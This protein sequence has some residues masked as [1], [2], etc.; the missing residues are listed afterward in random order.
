ME[1]QM[2]CVLGGQQA[3]LQQDEHIQRVLTQLFSTL[4]MKLISHPS[5]E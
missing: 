2:F 4:G 5:K 1:S 3:V